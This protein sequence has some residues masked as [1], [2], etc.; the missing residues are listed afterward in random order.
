MG[1]VINQL[2][3]NI[4]KQ[5]TMPALDKFYMRRPWGDYSLH[6]KPQPDRLQKLNPVQAP[7]TS[8]NML[9]QP[10]DPRLGRPL[11]ADVRPA[12]RSIRVPAGLDSYKPVPFFAFEGVLVFTAL[13]ARAGEKT[14]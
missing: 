13:G 10:P 2:T 7:R 12:F 3:L 1:Y 6:E 9:L 5:D 14:E 8:K 4:E 11:Q